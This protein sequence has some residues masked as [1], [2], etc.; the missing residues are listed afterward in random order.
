MNLPSA[1]YSANGIVEAIINCLVG[2]Y[3]IFYPGKNYFSCKTGNK[4]LTLTLSAIVVLRSIEQE[5]KMWYNPG[6]SMGLVQPH[7]DQ[8][9]H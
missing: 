4:R 2:H 1:E 8:L 5:W 7:D 3:Y 6:H 9:T